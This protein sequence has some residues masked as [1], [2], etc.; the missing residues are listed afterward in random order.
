[1]S[2]SLVI[3]SF[4]KINKSIQKKVL[5]T[6]FLLYCFDLEIQFLSGIDQNFKKIIFL[7][8]GS[9]ILPGK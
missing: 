6:L 1:M 4:K 5:L 3:N 7:Q 2:E 8:F 9:E